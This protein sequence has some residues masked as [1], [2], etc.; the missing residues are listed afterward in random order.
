MRFTPILFAITGCSANEMAQSW[1]I[2]RMRILAVQA[3]VV[4]ETGALT[5]QAEP[6]PGDT[7]LLRS[8]TVHP[9][10][11]APHVIWTGCV[12]ESS[13][14][15]GCTP[16]DDGD[17]FLGIEPF[18]PPSFVVPA[19]VLD[20][21][22]EEEKQEGLSYLLTLI[23]VPDI[24]E[25]DEDLSPD[26]FTTDEEIATKYIPIS[27]AETPN[28]N[29]FVEQVLVEKVPV[30]TGTTLTVSPG[31]SYLFEPVL[32][33]GPEEYTYINSSGEAETRTE[34]PYFS[35]YSTE[36]SFDRPF[37]DYENDPGVSWTAPSDP[38]RSEARLW[39]VVRD[40]RG[41][42]GWVEQT[43]LFE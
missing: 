15:F 8:L 19:D 12:S 25:L 40:G 43:L 23:A 29:P 11:E 10:I 1:E 27:L 31:Q 32:A 41:G 30:G 21:L 38:M 39:I 6:Q 7:V 14:A 33:F 18:A 37:S 26:A 9:E 36:G 28:N 2:D 35:W 24:E 22:T 34:E 3:S 20:E 4:D 16:S 42:M 5:P 13:D 17:G